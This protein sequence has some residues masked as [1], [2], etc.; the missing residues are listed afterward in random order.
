[1][2]ASLADARG[3]FFQPQILTQR[4]EFRM[5]LKKQWIVIFKADPLGPL[6][7]E[8]HPSSRT[9]DSMHEAEIARQR[10]NQTG[11]AVDIIEIEFDP[12]GSRLP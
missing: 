4:D 6:A 11:E 10:R 3:L 2:S 9:Y 7:G 1:M 12:S 5:S 8:F